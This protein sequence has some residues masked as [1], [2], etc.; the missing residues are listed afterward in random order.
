MA[1][2]VLN[3]AKTAVLLADFHADGMGAN[4]L[5]KERHVIENSSTVAD[6]ARRA[7]VQVIY[8][9]VN[10]RQEYP[11]VSDRNQTFQH[12]ITMKKTGPQPP[13]DPL[14][15]IV[16]ELPPKPGDI[17]VVKHRVSALYGTELA[18]ILSAQGIEILVLLG[19]STGGVI[20]STVLE[21][22][23]ADYELVV[24]EDGSA[25]MDHDVHTFL[26]EGVF[27]RKG[28]VTTSQEVVKALSSG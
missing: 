8:I 9:V 28:T 1:E 17:V 19:H 6:A 24:V 3:K 13:K 27:P 11:E 25:D 22:S 14:S 26:M 12:I 15:L 16:P 10:F 21:A 4:P 23:D 18:Q 2:L 5:V 20:L 7:G